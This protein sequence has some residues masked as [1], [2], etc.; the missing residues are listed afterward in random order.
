MYVW[1]LLPHWVDY[2]DFDITIGWTA[3]N[4]SDCD[5]L[6][7]GFS[8]FDDVVLGSDGIYINTSHLGRRIYRIPL[9]DA[10]N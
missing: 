8:L 3:I 4:G 6:I 10:I 2:D 1:I 5:A 9:D 7:Y